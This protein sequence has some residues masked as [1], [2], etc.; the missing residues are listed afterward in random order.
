M[1]E[2]IVAR[3]E[4]Q[5]PVDPRN[6]IVRSRNALADRH[7]ATCR[8]VQHHGMQAFLERPRPVGDFAVSIH[9]K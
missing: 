4:D 6:V 8:G 3:A 5:R 9:D 7:D 1:V 2:D